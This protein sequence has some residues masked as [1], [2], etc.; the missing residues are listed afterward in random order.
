MIDDR[1]PVPAGPSAPD[2]QRDAMVATADLIAKILD[3]SVKIPGTHFYLGLDPLLGLIP[4]IGDMLANLMGTVI[5]GLAAHLQVPPIVIA[6]MSLNLLINGAV[7]AIPIL[8]DL[9]SVW[10]RSHAR[11]AVLLRLAATQPYRT[12]QRDW[13]YVT[14][15]IGGTAVLLLL[16][17]ALVLW[18]VLKLWAYF[19]L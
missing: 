15:I 12:T 18:I 19:E 8:G 3:T 6:R 13:L 14:G 16:A 2:L 11:N 4:G 1:S 9:F 5:L 10:F 7:G 17:I